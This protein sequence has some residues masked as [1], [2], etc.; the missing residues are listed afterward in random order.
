MQNVNDE[1]GLPATYQLVAYQI[2]RNSGRRPEVQFI[3]GCGKS[4]GLLIQ[5]GK[6]RPVYPDVC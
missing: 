4:R 6:Q 1:H 2:L 3:Q 5:T